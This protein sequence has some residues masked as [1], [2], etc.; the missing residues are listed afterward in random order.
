VTGARPPAPQCARDGCTADARW[1][2]SSRR[3]LRYCT[4]EHGTPASRGRCRTGKHPYP[5]VGE[6]CRACK[7]ERNAEYMRRK[8]AAEGLPE[9]RAKPAPAPVADPMPAEASPG[10]PPPVW[11]PA[12]MDRWPARGGPGDAG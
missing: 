12:G 8:R 10:P 11:R 5:G 2:T 7:T 4:P 3:W 9:P 6:K 1:S